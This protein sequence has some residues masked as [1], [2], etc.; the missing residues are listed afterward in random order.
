MSKWDD[1]YERLVAGS[2]TE[3]CATRMRK[4]RW[5]RLLVTFP[6]LSDMRVPDVGSTVDSWS[7]CPVRPAH[8]TLLN[9]FPT[10]DEPAGG[11]QCIEGDACRP[12][13]SVTDGD[14]DL[15][16][17]NSFLEHVGGHAR[18][19]EFSDSVRSLA[20]DYW[21]Q[22]PNRYFPIAPQWIVPRIQF[23]PVAAR[24]TVAKNWPLYK[25]RSD[26]RDRALHEMLEIEL[27]SRTEIHRLA[28][29]ARMARERWP[30]FT[31]SYIVLRSCSDFEAE[32]TTPGA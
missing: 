23:L 1:Y 15:V 31:K 6:H 21:I 13:R 30:G 32:R 5:D 7:L 11:F 3:S 20:P 16:Y 12:P 4:R 26:D 19:L 18:R 17:S 28:L 25:W 27:L 10:P 22:T 14:W 2:E 8:V 29:D 9:I 24:T